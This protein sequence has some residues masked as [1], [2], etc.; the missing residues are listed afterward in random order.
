MNWNSYDLLGFTI[1]CQHL[2]LHKKNQVFD[3]FLI[4]WRNWEFRKSTWA[5]S[6]GRCLWA[7]P[8]WQI[9]IFLPLY[10]LSY[11][12]CNFKIRRVRENVLVWMNNW[13]K[14]CK[15][16]CE[17]KSSVEFFSNLY[18]DFFLFSNNLEKERS[19]EMW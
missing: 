15:E 13:Q 12:D 4:F 17:G 11:Y 19:N 3:V 14:Y 10:N 5:I 1:P 8:V 6:A 7:W 18:T 2:P 9:L 16:R